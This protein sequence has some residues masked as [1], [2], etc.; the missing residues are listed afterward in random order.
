MRYSDGVCGESEPALFVFFIRLD[1]LLS[2]FIQ[3]LGAVEIGSSLP[4]LCLTA[5]QPCGTLHG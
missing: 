1:V 5:A 2:V 4:K 3:P